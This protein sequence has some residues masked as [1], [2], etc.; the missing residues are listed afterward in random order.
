VAAVLELGYEKYLSREFK[1]EFPNLLEAA[2]Q[3]D[4]SEKPSAEETYA[5]P[6][7]EAI[8]PPKSVTF[9][10]GIALHGGATSPVGEFG[11]T[12]VVRDPP[13]S[14]ATDGDILG[15]EVVFLFDIASLQTIFSLGYVENHFGNDVPTTLSDDS[16]LQF[17]TPESEIDFEAVRFGVRVLPWDNSIIRPMIG[18]GV[19]YGK[20]HARSQLFS[21]SVGEIGGPDDPA[22]IMA[23]SESEY[24]F[25]VYGLAGMSLQTSK[26]VSLNGELTYN[27]LFSEDAERTDTFVPREEG[28][29]QTE[30]NS[31]KSNSEW[32]EIRAGVILY[33]PGLGL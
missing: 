25:G 10:F 33:F 28:G 8:T 4:L 21:E 3:Y 22:Q 24:L 18:S 23:T 11:R 5:H 30:K 32:W 26:W 20:L 15:F 12:D 19:H 16:T 27:F 2:R 6:Y 14:G 31:I 29:T 9:I 1:E 7:V 17:V 13:K